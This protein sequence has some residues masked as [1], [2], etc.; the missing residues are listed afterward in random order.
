MI[1]RPRD[2]IDTPITGLIAVLAASLHQK[3][4]SQFGPTDTNPI[5]I[6]CCS[7]YQ[8]HSYFREFKLVI[9]ILGW[10][11]MSLRSQIYCCLL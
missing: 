9:F 11:I 2:L 6:S 4:Y 3:G 8:P 5:W 10:A 7:E 1:V